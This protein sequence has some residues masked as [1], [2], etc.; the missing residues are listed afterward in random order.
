M[1]MCFSYDTPDKEYEYEDKEVN[2]NGHKM[3]AMFPKN[4]SRVT[5]IFYEWKDSN[6]QDR[7]DGW[8]NISDWHLTFWILWNGNTVW[9]C[10]TDKKWQERHWRD[11][12]MFRLLFALE[13]DKEREKIKKRNEIADCKATI[14]RCT[15]RLTQLA[16]KKK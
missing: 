13:S 11:G 15:A 7:Q 10:I 3:K 8:A 2:I 14:K 6:W 9:E 4:H 1:G 5:G 12:G 16:G